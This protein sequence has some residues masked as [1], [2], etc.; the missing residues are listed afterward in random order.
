MSLWGHVQTQILWKMPKQL[1][2]CH[3]LANICFLS[4][5]CLLNIKL[6]RNFHVMWVI[7]SPSLW[8]EQRLTVLLKKWVFI[9]IRY[10]AL[11]PMLC[12]CWQHKAAWK[13]LLATQCSLWVWSCVLQSCPL[14]SQQDLWCLSKA[15]GVVGAMGSCLQAICKLTRSCC[16]CRM[17][18]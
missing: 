12:L 13:I 10:Q 1:I 6:L 14:C 18:Y 7:C 2:N 4:W 15:S 11:N 5:N 17:C 8:K 3:Y 9:L 16:M